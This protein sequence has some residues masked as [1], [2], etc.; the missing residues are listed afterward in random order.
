MAAPSP[1]VAKAAA[2]MTG[3]EAKDF[4]KTKHKGLPEKKAVKEATSEM[5]MSPQEL[6]LQKRK[7]AID[8]MIAKKRQQEFRKSK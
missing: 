8:V 7:S 6:N 3:K 5:P 2:S 4:A 1:E